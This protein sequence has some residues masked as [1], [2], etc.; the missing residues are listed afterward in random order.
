MGAG[1]QLSAKRRLA[2]ASGIFVVMVGFVGQ[3]AF[4]GSTLITFTTSVNSGS[5]TLAELPP[6]FSGSTTDLTA[7]GASLSTVTA[8]TTTVTEILA[9]GVNPFSVTA[10]VC[11][12]AN[13]TTPAAVNGEDCTNLPNQLD[14]LSGGAVTSVIQGS[15]I[16]ATNSTLTHVGTPQGTAANGANSTMSAPITL[17]S[18][19]GESPTTAYNGVY[20]NRTALAVSNVFD[21]GTYYGYWITTLV[22]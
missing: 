11:G 18:V 15:Q 21:A 4:A 22:T 2:L 13:L 9:S 19:T 12:P 10:Q 14:A 17:L 7:N 20:A 16:A 8:A 6:V 3:Q 1:R 5:R